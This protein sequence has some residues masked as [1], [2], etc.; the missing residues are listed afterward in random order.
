MY[1]QGKMDTVRNTDGADTVARFRTANMC[2]TT[3][4]PYSH[5]MRVPEQRHDVEPGLHQS[6]TAARCRRCGAR[7]TIP[8]YSNTS[9]GV[10]C[11]AMKAAY[12]FFASVR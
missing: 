6:M 3:T 11:F 8:Q 5:V 2:T 7:T 12:D 1:I 4:M 10:P 9:H